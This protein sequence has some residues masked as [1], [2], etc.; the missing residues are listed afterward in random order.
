MSMKRTAWIT[1]ALAL[2]WVGAS[3]AAFA[4][5]NHDEH[6]DQH[7]APHEGGPHPQA[8][9]PY[10]GPP[11]N[12]HPGEVHPAPM[13]QGP[14]FRGPSGPGHFDGFQGQGYGP[15]APAQFVYHGRSSGSFRAAPFAYPRGWGYRPW[16]Y[17]QFLPALFLTPN[18]FI[19]N[20]GGYGLAP[21]PYGC[22]WVRYGPDALLVNIYTGQILEVVHG[23][24]WW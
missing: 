3:A 12:P 1:A 15:H 18:Y 6:H 16:A 21:P 5:D 9:A 10:H 22:N 4:Q 19:G 11:A 17:G 20:W 24:F 13:A 8:N 7:G 14:A 2:T 23:V